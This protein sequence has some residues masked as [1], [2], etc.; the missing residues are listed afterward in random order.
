MFCT[1]GAAPECRAPCWTCVLV[2]CRVNVGHAVTP[3]RDSQE[4]V[5]LLLR[6]VASLSDAGHPCQCRPTSLARVMGSQATRHAGREAAGGPLA[7]LSG[8]NGPSQA[9]C[10][11][12]CN[13]R[14]L[15]LCKTRHNIRPAL[16]PPP[17]SVMKTADARRMHRRSPRSR[18]TGRWHC[19][20]RRRR[21]AAHPAARPTPPGTAPWSPAQ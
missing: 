10:V 9:V 11:N 15:H 3:C 16:I 18:G 7:A 13:A 5:A 17:M 4:A 14:A 8:A 20:R 1:K 21:P 19:C 6:W 12:A 2:R